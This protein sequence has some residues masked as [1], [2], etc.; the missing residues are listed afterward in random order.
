LI[1]P[2]GRERE[3]G[4]GDEISKG[5]PPRGARAASFSG[6]GPKCGNRRKAEAARDAEMERTWR[7]GGRRAC[8]GKGKKRGVSNLEIR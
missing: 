1:G 2:P 6:H 8:K 7:W 5:K 4:G 3:L